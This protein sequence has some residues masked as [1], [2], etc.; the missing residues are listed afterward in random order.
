MGLDFAPWCSMPAVSWLVK[1]VA[2]HFHFARLDESYPDGG[3]QLED[4]KLK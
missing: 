2:V 4:D 1:L 3:I